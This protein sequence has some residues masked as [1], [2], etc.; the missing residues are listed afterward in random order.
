M[1]NEKKALVNVPYVD[2]SYK[3]AGG[4]ILSTVGDLIKY[5]NQLLKSYQQTDLTSNKTYLNSSTMKSYLWSPQSQPP[6]D[7]LP[8]G[9]GWHLKLDKENNS[10]V[11]YV[12]HTG[13]AVGS[14]TCLLIIPTDSNG[15]ETSGLVV[16]I[17]CNL[18]DIR[19]I[20]KLSLRISD[21]FMDKY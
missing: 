12:Y 10:K 5:G 1:R 7:D 6:K 19:E 18:Q 8:Y 9:L 17:L 14:T 15:N 20:V 3:W 4:G 11:K 2:N 21:I 16:S 13:G